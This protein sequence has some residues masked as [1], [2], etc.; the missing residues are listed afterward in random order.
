[1]AWLP[2]K[3]VVVPIDFSGTSVEAVGTALEL[4]DSP[5]DVHVL[6][7]VMPLDNMSSG[8][9]WGAIDDRSREEAVEEH[10]GEFLKTHGFTGV[11]TVVRVGDPG[12]EIADY[13]KDASSKLIVIPSHGHHGVKRMLLG[14]VAE[15]V[16]RHAECAV[17]VLRRDDA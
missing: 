4:V 2:Q 8:M 16:I 6:H 10:F 7:V 3:T 15:R 17:L 1:M 14:S 11:T 12:L 9:N 5:S 13:A